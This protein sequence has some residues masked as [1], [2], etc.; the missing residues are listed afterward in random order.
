MPLPSERT[1]FSKM[2]RW[3]IFPNVCIRLWAV[4]P[5]YDDGRAVVY[6]AL[7]ASVV[8]GGISTSLSHL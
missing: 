1:R 8:V 7:G 6:T 2:G 3:L 4:F 5:K